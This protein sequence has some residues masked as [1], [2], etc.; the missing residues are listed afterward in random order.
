MEHCFRNILLCQYFFLYVRLYFYYSIS[1]NVFIF[2]PTPSFLLYFV[3]FPQPLL[4]FVSAFLSEPGT[5]FIQWQ[6]LGCPLLSSLNRRLLNPP[7]LCLWSNPPPLNLQSLKHGGCVHPFVVCL[8]AEWW[9]VTH[10]PPQCC[11]ILFF[12]GCFWDQVAP[13]NCGC[14]EPVCLLKRKDASF[15]KCSTCQK[16][17]HLIIRNCSFLHLSIISM[18][19]IQMQCSVEPVEEGAKY[20]VSRVFIMLK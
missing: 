18:Q 6:R 9:H 2:L 10:N 20:H 15:L 7:L 16:R 11:L 13:V 14:A 17:V 8:G 3:V 4:L 5:V 1:Y 12:P 19:V